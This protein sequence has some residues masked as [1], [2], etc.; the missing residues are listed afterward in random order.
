MDNLELSNER[1][2]QELNE[3]IWDDEERQKSPQVSKTK[4]SFAPKT[5]EEIDKLSRREQYE[6]KIELSKF[7]TEELKKELREYQR[8]ESKVNRSR[9]NKRLIILGRFL[10]TQMHQRPD[11]KVQYMVVESHLNQYLTNDR[12]R[13]LLGFPPLNAD[14]EN[15]ENN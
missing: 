9:E 11:R 4:K 5:K 14:E 10:D 3:P 6:Y 8:R 2:Q 13:E 15:H 12:E 7:R 1:V